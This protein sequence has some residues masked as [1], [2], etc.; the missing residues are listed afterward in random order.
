MGGHLRGAQAIDAEQLGHKLVEPVL[1][2]I[3]QI[4]LVPA[5][6]IFQLSVS[7]HHLFVVLIGLGASLLQQ[8]RKIFRGVL[9][10][11]RLPLGGGRRPGRFRP[12][13]GRLRARLS[14][15]RAQLGRIR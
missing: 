4:P 6:E 8:P 14:R 5:L 11:L 15:R 10:E 7:P 9:G 3:L 12:R 1:V 2:R 13:V